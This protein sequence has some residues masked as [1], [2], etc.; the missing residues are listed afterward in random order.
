MVFKL[1]KLNVDVPDVDF[2]AI[3]PK[4]YMA[5]SRKH[6]TSV[7]VAKFASEF[8]AEKPGAKVLDIGSGVGKFCLIGA[9]NTWGHFTGVEQRQDLVAVARRMAVVHNIRNVDFIHDNMTSV[10]F[11]DFNSFYF[12]NS[13]YENIDLPNRIDDSVSLDIKLYH[14]YCTYL[15]GQ[16]AALPVGSRLVTYCS[17]TSIIPE[18]FKL[19]DSGCGGLLKFLEK[20]SGR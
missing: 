7:N 6:W 19:V 4:R 10:R 12:Y 14:K 18:A 16:L 9:V 3:F 17:P 13:F 8:L 5:I 1:L 20:S 11:A 15:V 2:D